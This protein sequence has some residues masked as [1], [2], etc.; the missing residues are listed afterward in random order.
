M[1]CYF[2]QFAWAEIRFARTY[3]S[4]VGFGVQT[5]SSIVWI[6]AQAFHIV[7]RTAVC[8]ELATALPELNF[9]VVIDTAQFL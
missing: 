8:F 4:C 2:K 5:D 6:F 9:A 7:R 3:P 1:I